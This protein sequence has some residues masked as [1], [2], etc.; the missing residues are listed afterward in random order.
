MQLQTLAAS[1][2]L[3]WQKTAVVEHSS[4]CLIMPPSHI[5]DSERERERERRERESERERQ[6]ERAR[7]RE[8]ELDPLRGT[9]FQVLF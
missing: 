5:Q 1:L 9:T 7:E 3:E 4:A 2:R 8:R 6:G